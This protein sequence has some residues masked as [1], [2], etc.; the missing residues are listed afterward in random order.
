MSP[1]VSENHGAAKSG[2]A[3][4]H[5]PAMDDRRA[6]VISGWLTGIYFVVELGIGLWSGSIAVL[7]DAFHTSSAVGGVLIALVA[8][9]LGERVASPRL[10]FG[11]IRAQIVGALFN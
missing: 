7:S 1:S 11:W 8:L 5:M 2:H 10:T 4:H 6:L 3:G 9:Q